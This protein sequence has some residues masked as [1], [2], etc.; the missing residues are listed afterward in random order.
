MLLSCNGTTPFL[1]QIP[2]LPI[3]FANIMS[4]TNLSPTT[5]I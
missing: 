5:A 2:Q 4:V 3:V 1:T